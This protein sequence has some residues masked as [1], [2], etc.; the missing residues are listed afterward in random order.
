MSVT[1]L[2]AKAMGGGKIAASLGPSLG[3]VLSRFLGDNAKVTDWLLVLQGRKEPSDFM[4]KTAK[5]VAAI[6]G[7]SS[8]HDGIRTIVLGLAEGKGL[9]EAQV[10]ELLGSIAPFVGAV[11]P[12]DFPTAIATINALA[13]RIIESGDDFQL[14]AITTCPYCS[15]T[16]TI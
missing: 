2:L 5:Y 6:T 8:N 3:P 1:S 9:N 4:L 14:R 13:K 15:E 16:F 11:P 10:I 12:T 7:E